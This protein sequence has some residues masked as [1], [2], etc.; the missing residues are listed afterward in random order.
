MKRRGREVE[1]KIAKKTYEVFLRVSRAYGARHGNVSCMGTH[2]NVWTALH[3]RV[4]RVKNCS[5]SAWGHTLTAFSD[6]LRAKNTFWGILSVTGP[7]RWVA[8]IRRAGAPWVNRARY[9]TQHGAWKGRLGQQQAPDH[10][11]GSNREYFPYL[12]SSSTRVGVRGRREGMVRSSR[13]LGVSWVMGLAHGMQM[14]A[15][16]RPQE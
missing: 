8:V 14:G 6:E 10:G 3:R 12:G 9:D 4:G 2:A 11:G 5:W 7:R 13:A 15:W 16:G 1:K